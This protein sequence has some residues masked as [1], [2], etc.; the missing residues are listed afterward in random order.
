MEPLKQ[1]AKNEVLMRALEAYF[2]EV[3]KEMVIEKAFRGHEVKDIVE[4]SNVIEQLF[5]RLN[6]RYNEDRKKITSDST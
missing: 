4:A 1:I 3:L 6:K 2:E 5:I